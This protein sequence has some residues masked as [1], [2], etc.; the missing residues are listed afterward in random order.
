MLGSILG[1]RVYGHLYL[2]FVYRYIDVYACVSVCIYIYVCRGRC[3][4]ACIYH[5]H[6]YTRAWRVHTVEPSVAYGT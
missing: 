6:V 3:R 5:R 1:T 4:F 2:F